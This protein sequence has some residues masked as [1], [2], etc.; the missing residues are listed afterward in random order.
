MINF[1][2]FKFTSMNY[3]DNFENFEK[4][5]N[6]PE[7]PDELLKPAPDVASNVGEYIQVIKARLA[8]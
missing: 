5:Q 1:S 3:G 4:L 7:F 2:T 6:K 8:R